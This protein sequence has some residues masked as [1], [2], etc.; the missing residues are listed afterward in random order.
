VRIDAVQTEHH[1]RIEHIAVGI[2]EFKRRAGKA[3]Q[4]AVA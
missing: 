1:G 4:I 3:R 2:A